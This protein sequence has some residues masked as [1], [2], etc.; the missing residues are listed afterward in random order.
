MFKKILIANRGE[1]ACRVIL[2]CKRLNIATIA[3]Y[4]DADSH[5]RHVKIAD[6]A[7]HIGGSRPTESYLHGEKI[8][9]VAKSSGAEAIHPGYGFVSENADFARACKAADIVFIGPTPDAIQAMGSKSAAKALMEKAGVPVVPGY[10]G[11]EQA[12]HFLAKEAKRIGYPLLIKAIAGGGGKGMRL[13][14]Q[15]DEFLPQLEAAKRE[16]KNSFGDDT[17]L[18]ERYVD[19]PHHIEFQVFGDSHGNVVHLFERE[20]SIQRRHQKILEETPSPFLDDK[21]RN[22]MAD[23]AVAAATAIGY[24]NAG[25]IEFIVGSDRKFFF[26]EMNTRLQVEHPVTEMTTG[27]DL[28]EWQLRVAAG[29]PLPL[30][31]E[32]IACKG[33]AI[34]V[35]ICA[36]NP[37]NQFLPEIGPLHRFV[38]PTVMDGIRVDTGVLQGDEIGIF[39]DSMIAKLIAYGDNRQQAQ[40]KLVAALAHTAVVGVK[41]NIEFLAKVATEPAFV[42]GQVDTHFIAQHRESLLS[43]PNE[44]PHRALI[45]AAVALLRQNEIAARAKL[46]GSSDPYSPWGIPNSWRLNGA[47]A[48]VLLFADPLANRTREVKVQGG[49][50]QYDFHVE[51]QSYSV[52]TQS[53]NQ[54]EMKLAIAGRISSGIVLYYEDHY[55]VDV[56]SDRYEFLSVQPFAFDHAEEVASGRLTALMP[57][58]IVKV[59]VSVGDVVAAGQPLLIM[60]A[61]KMEH[62]IHSPREGTI[63]EVFYKVDDIVAADAT[64]FG[65]ES[66]SN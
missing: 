25:T 40:K 54:P 23:A 28:V 8:L 62:T 37:A 5:A 39:Y 56:D 33:H 45:F 48:Q 12:P 6:E 7:W 65:F 64:L 17:V 60:E 61:M 32:N 18:I 52:A 21:L 63:E 29:E 58:R 11:A 42:A 50:G 3:V 44:A 57:G 46:H 36:E 35:R 47:G 15:P 27:L 59:M 66:A 30:K 26:M 41:T 53:M 38:Y 43:Q 31:Q 14:T 19:G 20:C 10:H 55:L 22:Q 34:E 2:T 49:A 16:A 51:D 1:I 9:D 24:S 13:V 4:S